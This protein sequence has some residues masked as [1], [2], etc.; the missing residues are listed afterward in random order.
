MTGT[1]FCMSENN[2][3]AM[4]KVGFIDPMLC[5]GCIQF[6]YRCLYV[7]VRGGIM[8]QYFLC[9]LLLM[10]IYQTGCDDIVL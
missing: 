5:G 2:C 10:K 7:T 1:K 8:L 3:S 4:L 6:V 9:L